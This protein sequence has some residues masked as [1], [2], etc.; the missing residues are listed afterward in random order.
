MP[1]GL[2][3]LFLSHGAPDILLR[4]TAAAKFLS[5]LGAE[6]SEPKAIVIISAHWIDDPVGITTGERL[7]TIHDFGGFPES[8]Y[9]ITYPAKGDDALSERIAF[10]LATA[11]IEN[12]LI[13]DRGLDHGAWILLRL[14][15][16]DA[17]IPVVQVS[18]P[19]GTL[20]EHAAL[21]EALSPLRN[22]DVLIIGSGS[23]VHNLRSLNRENRTDPWAEEF[24]E[25]LKEA[26][27]GNHFDWLIDREVLPSNFRQAHPTIEHYVPLVVA[28][29]AGG[30]DIPGK[31]IHQS[32][33]YG[34]IGMG[35][36]AFDA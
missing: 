2:P 20:N 7:K 36:Y 23:T 32:F 27:E 26:I 34:N 14:M 11:G 21:G 8:L 5:G 4:E 25:W 33:D 24:E 12:Q 3:T 31:R 16:P 15:Y 28:W 6:L 1:Q 29:A 9:Q 35:M 18:L 30:S 10:L 17:R 13:G 22:E 19:T